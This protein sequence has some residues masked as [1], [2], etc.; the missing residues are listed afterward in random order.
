MEFNKTNIILGAGVGLG[1][2]SSSCPVGPLRS[3][4][5]PARAGLH[6]VLEYRIAGA[7]MTFIYLRDLMDGFSTQTLYWKA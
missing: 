6:L 3:S 4:G 1:T 2:E 7:H 5:K